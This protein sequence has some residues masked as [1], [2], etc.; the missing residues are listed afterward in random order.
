MSQIKNE[1][2]VAYLLDKPW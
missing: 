1:R 2:K